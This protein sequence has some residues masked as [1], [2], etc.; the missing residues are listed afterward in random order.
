M[1]LVKV[2]ST[3]SYLLDDDIL[4]SLHPSADSVWPL[5]YKEK[6]DVDLSVD[7]FCRP[8]CR[9]AIN[10]FFFFFLGCQLLLNCKLHKNLHSFWVTDLTKLLLIADL[11]ITL[12]MFFFS[13]QIHSSH[14]PSEFTTLQNFWKVHNVTCD[15][16]KNVSD[17]MTHWRTDLILY[18]GDPTRLVE[19]C[20]WSSQEAF[21]E[22]FC[23]AQ[24][25]HMNLTR[26]IDK[27][28]LYF[29]FCSS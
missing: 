25:H 20:I 29:G 12:S 21:Q 28:K 19:D 13:F 23:T 18:S 27:F 11:Q 7:V 15:A 2:C 6:L 24:L 16:L 17:N 22:V 10:N 1:P 8:L 5:L 3:S 14:S 9:P 4:Y 26:D